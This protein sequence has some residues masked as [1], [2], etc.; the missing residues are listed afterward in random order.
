M[1]EENQETP[2]VNER[3]FLHL[4]ENLSSKEEALTI[5]ECIAKKIK[6]KNSSDEV[7]YIDSHRLH[8]GRLKTTYTPS[9]LI[10]EEE[11]DYL[12]DNNLKIIQKSASL[13]QKLSENYKHI[14]IDDIDN[15]LFISHTDTQER[16]YQK[17]Q[18]FLEWICFQNFKQEEEGNAIIENK[19][20]HL[21]SSSSKDVTPL[22]KANNNPQGGKIYHSKNEVIGESKIELSNLINHQVESNKEE[23][24]NLFDDDTMTTKESTPLSGTIKLDTLIMN[25]NTKWGDLLLYKTEDTLYTP[26]VLTHVIGVAPLSTQ[27]L[28]ISPFKTKDEVKRYMQTVHIKIP[29]SLKSTQRTKFLT[30]E[31]F[32]GVS[33]EK[34]KALMDVICQSMVQFR[35]RLDAMGY[36]HGICIIDAFDLT[37][38]GAGA[39]IAL[40]SLRWYDL[41]LDG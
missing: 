12:F 11:I 27:L 17:R 3:I 31:N 40:E 22:F 21:L 4:Y 39:D 20:F 13:L 2:S 41:N 10:A 24:I 15:L 37:Q 38:Y 23:S 33:L 5:A 34:E 16:K 26:Y 14:I 6:E 28:F 32:R 1:N 30:V 9:T 8:I 36:T 7:L 19:V 18:S 29:Y 25:N 35:E